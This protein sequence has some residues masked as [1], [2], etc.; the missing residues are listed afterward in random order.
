MKVLLVSPEVSPLS[1]TGG[2][3]DVAGALPQALRQVGVDA[4]VLC[5][6]YGFIDPEPLGKTRQAGSIRLRI[7]GAARR[8]KVIETK[9]PATDV[10]LYLL[11]HK[12]S[13]DRKGIY[14]DA[15]GDFTDNDERFLLLAQSALA[16]PSAINWTPDV[17]HLHDW[18]VALTPACLNALP[19]GDAR[20]QWASVLTIHNLMHQGVFPKTVLDKSEL[21]HEFYNANGLEHNGCL[22]MLKGGIHHATKITT[23]SPTYS[24]EIQEEPFAHGLQK[25]LKHRAADL[26]GIING[27]D[28]A[29]WDPNTDRSLIRNYSIPDVEVGKTACKKDLLETLGLPQEEKRPLFF[30]VSRLDQQKGLDLLAN[31]LPK[32]I[33]DHDAAFALLGSGDPL[34]EST[35]KSISRENPDRVAAVIGFDEKLARK[36]FA[37]GDFLVVPSR[38][39]PCGLTQL[40]AMRYGT[41]PVVR[42]TGGLA[43]TV[44]PWRPGKRSATGIV[45]EGM[46]EWEL[47]LALEQALKVYRSH[48][49]FSALRRN[50]MQRDS[51]WEP[52]A[53]Y[54]A[55][56]YSWAVEQRLKTIREEEDL[57][58]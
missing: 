54:Y 28:C 14:S 34:L 39:E 46:G 33:S 32:L 15:N 13:F 23:V 25:S 49:T 35:Y 43:D 20:R 40:Y 38:F 22:N 42:E 52:S 3:G 27:I 31:V 51:S 1:K 10:P 4:R 41:I 37:G 50:G 26:I 9:L 16:L 6:L 48:K 53:K 45:Y 47:F 24:R 18:T 19:S 58:P 2:L 21:P 11:Q 36:L 57:K 44:T 12:R 5:P 55:K 8:A 17:L 56:T 7:G 29:Q 30:V